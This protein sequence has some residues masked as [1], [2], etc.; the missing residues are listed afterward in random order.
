MCVSC[1]SDG[2]RE[3]KR[4]GK[5]ANPSPPQSL[6]SR[7]LMHIQLS[8]PPHCPS[9]LINAPVVGVNKHIHSGPKNK[10]HCVS[11]PWKVE[12]QLLP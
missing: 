1:V 4:S 12:M 11:N 5:R 8:I 2:W 9:F 6:Q 3:S 7:G 10:A